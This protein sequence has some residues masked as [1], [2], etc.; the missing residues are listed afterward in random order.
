MSNTVERLLIRI[1]AT[2]EQLRREMAAADKAVVKHQATVEKAQGA[3]ARGWGGAKD[4][5]AKHNTE[6]KLVAAAAAAATGLAMRAVIKYSDS[7]KNLQGQLKLVTK[8]SSE[9][10]RVYDATKAIA[11]ETGQSLDATVNLYAR[12]TRATQ[13]LGISETDRLRITENVNKA[14]IV[15]G[16]S[17][18]EA[19]AAIKQLSQG[20]AS[21]VLRGEELNSVMENS[22]RLAKAL[23]DGLGVPLG[24]LRKMGSEGELTSEKVTGALLGMSEAIDAEF[25]KMPMTV[26]RAWNRIEVITQDA[27][28]KADMSPLIEGI[29]D[30][31]EALNDPAVISGLT[32]IAGGIVKVTVAAGKSV[33]ALGGMAKAT[34][35]WIASIVA[36]FD[37]DDIGNIGAELERLHAQLKYLEEGGAGTSKRADA[38]REK[39]A[40]YEAI[41]NLQVELINNVAD[42]R[43]EDGKAADKQ[44]EAMAGLA[45]I[46]VRAET[47]K[48]KVLAGALKSQE[49]AQRAVEKAAETER[50][51]VEKVNDA[52]D[53]LDQQ[54]AAIGMN[55][56]AQVIYNATMEAAKYAH[57][58]EIAK[59]VEKTVALYDQ[60][61]ALD[62]SAKKA[63]ETK[64]AAV[65]AAEDSLQPWKD[66]LGE[67]VADI[68]GTFVDAWVGAFDGT[69][70]NFGDFAKRIK[71]ALFRLL[72][73]MA[74]L[75]VTRPITMQLS[76]AMGG[77]SVAGGATAGT[78][79]AG[80]A[81]GISSA[82]S[83]ITTMGENFYHAIGDVAGKLGLLDFSSA[84]HEAGANLTGMGML[85]TGLAGMAGGFAGRA[86]FGNE[87]S[88]GLGAM[89]GTILGSILGGPIGAGIGSFIGEGIEAGVQKLFGQKNNGNNSGATDFNLATGAN[90]S[91][92]WGKSGSQENADAAAQLVEPL[93]R[94]AEAIG[95]SDL[96]GNITVGNRNGIQ[97]GGKS[98][99]RDSEAF[100]QFAFDEVVR[101]ASHLNDALKQLIINFDGTAEETATYAAAMISMTAA[102]ATNPVEVALNDALAQMDKAK[103]GFMGAYY[104]Q[105]EALNGL[106]SNYDGQASS[107]VALNDALI[108]TR[109]MAYD[110]AIAILQMSESI[111]KLLG[112]QSQYFREA[113][114][115]PEELQASRVAQRDAV[116]EAL[117]AATDPAQ[118][119]DL[120]TQFTELNRKVFD[121]LTDEG[122]LA[123]VGIF[124]ALNDEVNEIAQGI[125]GT[126]LD[127]LNVSQE[128]LNKRMVESITGAG[129][130]IQKAADDMGAHVKSFGEVITD[131][132]TRGI[133]IRVS[134]DGGAPV[135]VN[136]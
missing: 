89:G 52:I 74:H 63:E 35:E 61:T 109:Q 55:E 81:G 124:T 127:N 62:E 133:S 91:R 7:Y 70:K 58:E 96:A 41:Y 107:A 84:A 49:K 72:G 82:L 71:D 6:L 33:A 100:F 117:R 8:D 31:E 118:V 47:R 136:R 73:T 5:V 29:E 125:L 78:T 123:D 26:A 103:G 48:S 79:G 104:A 113:V 80:G 34:G 106:I 36:G 129:G 93:M 23:A 17:T 39:I 101:G 88:T 45:E 1:D 32:S 120:V 44:G 83:S 85:K 68:D 18:T 37:P 64:Q 43:E 24:Q 14:M 42:A 66:A 3:I 77:M 60:Q 54:L 131:L 90:V 87:Q 98:F 51:R 12:M 115:T 21:G 105:V 22:P 75:A 110:A 25:D 38:L 53:A 135:E 65:K 102:T 4:A 108:V 114:M 50:R 97:F 119:L 134:T 121:G 15:S 86:V 95:G 16:A 19:E 94:F 126:S 116:V 28:G 76:A 112:D 128:D 56:R 27:I 11:S 59:I 122:R 67:L 2:T 69:L 46:V 132:I 40:E 20:M 57:G 130:V 10:N 92:T 30:L 99:G 111:G 9:L 13:E